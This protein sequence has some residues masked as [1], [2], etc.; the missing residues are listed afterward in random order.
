M[1]DK[2]GR[3]RIL[4]VFDAS[5][6]AANQDV[7]VTTLLALRISTRRHLLRAEQKLDLTARKEAV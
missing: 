3:G 2:G 4:E 6:I 7:L 1:M 5:R